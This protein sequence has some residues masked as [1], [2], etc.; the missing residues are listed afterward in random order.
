[1]DYRAKVYDSLDY[2]EENLDDRIDLEDLAQKAYLSKY[3][4]H[5]LFHKVTGESVTRYIT[6]RRMAKAAE[7]LV[8]TEQPI[9]DIALKYQYA[10]QE[11]FTRAFMR[12]YGLAPG[13]Y[14]KIHGSRKPT[15]VINFSSFTKIVDM[16]A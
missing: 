13:K 15:K 10:S 14:R 11:S 1:M 16:V 8:E 4:Y 7:E 3:Y 9:I 5:R 6:R 12:I 2:I